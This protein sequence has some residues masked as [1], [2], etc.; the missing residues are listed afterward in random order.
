V[1]HALVTGSDTRDELVTAEGELSSFSSRVDSHFGHAGNS[2]P[3][4]NSSKSC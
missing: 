1:S 2:C 4:T 3:R